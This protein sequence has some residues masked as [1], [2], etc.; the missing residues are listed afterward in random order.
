MAE[1]VHNL[2]KNFIIMFLILPNNVNKQKKF[3]R[4]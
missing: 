1:I 3:M 4:H 2:A